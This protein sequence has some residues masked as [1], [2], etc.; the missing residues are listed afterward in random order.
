MEADVYSSI[1]IKFCELTIE[2]QTFTDSFQSMCISYCYKHIVVVK[3]YIVSHA[4]HL[5]FHFFKAH[6][7]TPEPMTAYIK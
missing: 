6:L 2:Y 7:R 1:Y 5:P 4:Q 3:T